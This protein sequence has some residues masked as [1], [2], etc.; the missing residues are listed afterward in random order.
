VANSYWLINTNRSE[1]R[2]FKKNTDTKEVIFPY[3]S[4]D[5]GKIVGTFGQDAPVMQRRIVLKVVEAR[6][7][8][9]KLISQ[10]WGVTQEVWNKPSDN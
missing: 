3:M 10:G 6:E 7:E 1:V 5:H 2:R 4:V 8:W 9:K